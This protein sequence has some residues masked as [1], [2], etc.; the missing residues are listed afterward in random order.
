[1]YTGGK[2]EADDDASYSGA[3]EEQPPVI[4]AGDVS[5]DDDELD[6]RDVLYFV[7]TPVNSIGRACRW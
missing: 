6:W 2:V 1:M 7:V 5:T 3:S 4:T